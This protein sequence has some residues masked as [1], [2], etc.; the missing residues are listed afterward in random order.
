MPESN[1]LPHRQP[2]LYLL[3]ALLGGILIDR[4]L[5]PPRPLLLGFFIIFLLLSTIFFFTKKN[6]SATLCL[7]FAFLFIGSL[8]SQS[9]RKDIA[10]NRLQ[11]LI[12]NGTVSLDEP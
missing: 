4:F 6:V 11:R 10:E 12:D 9:E 1:F 2:F 7:L 5:E 3:T 8:L